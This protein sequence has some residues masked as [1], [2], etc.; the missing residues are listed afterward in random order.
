[1]NGVAAMSA[2]GVYGK[3]RVAAGIVGTANLRLGERVADVLDAQIAAAG[4]RFRGIR[5]GASWDPDEAVP[6][7]APIPRSTC[8]YGATSGSASPV[9]AAPA[10]VRSLV[11]PPQIPDVTAL[12]R[13]FP[14]PRSS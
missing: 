10:D 8:C 9:G 1:V 3:T 7:T 4:G 6:I 14:T 11:L 12:A 2:S 5:L 13:A